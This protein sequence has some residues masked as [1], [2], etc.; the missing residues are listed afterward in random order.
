MTFFD[1]ISYDFKLLCQAVGLFG[2]ALHVYGFICLSAGRMDSQAPTYFILKIVAS[3]CVLVSLIVDFNMSSALI[4]IF[5]IA[6]AIGAV[7]VRQNPVRAT[8]AI[9]VPVETQTVSTR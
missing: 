8:A 1:S 7:F 3:A 2:F 4:Q 9:P 5:Y 6:I